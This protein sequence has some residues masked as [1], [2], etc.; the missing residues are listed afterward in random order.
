MLAAAAVRPLIPGQPG[1]P[2][3]FRAIT[4]IPCPLCGLTTSVTEAVHLR[5]GEALAVTPAG[6]VAVV[7]AVALLLARRRESVSVPSWLIPT[8]LALMWTYQLFRFSIL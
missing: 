8:T 2:C 4:G 7:L 5:L 3:P 1:L 6:V